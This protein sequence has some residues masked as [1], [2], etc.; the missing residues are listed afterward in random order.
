MRKRAQRKSIPVESVERQVDKT[1][2]MKLS[3]NKHFRNKKQ[4]WAA[5][6]LI[7][8]FLMVLL[9]TSFFNVSSGEPFN[10][11]G[12]GFSRYYLA[13][14][15]P[16]YNMRI[17][18]ET[19]YGENAGQYPFYGNDDPLLNYPLGR[20][21]GR[22]PFM[23]VLA[24]STGQ[25]L[26][27][28][29]DEVDAVGYAMQFLPALFGALLVFPIYFIGKTLFNKKV[30]LL[31]ALL[32]ALIPVHLG[33]GHG[34]AYALFDH[35]SL[36]LFLIVTSYLFVIKG[37]T[38][39][40]KNKSYLYAL[41]AGICVAA[42]TMVWV[43]ARYLFTMIALY[44][45]VQIIIDIYLG[46]KDVSV[47]RTAS[48]TL[49]S[50][51]LISLP[52]IASRGGFSPDLNLYLALGVTAFG[53]IYYLFSKKNIPWTLSLPAIFG[54][55]AGGVVFLYF[56]PTVSQYF[57]VFG[58]L[59]KIR[60][61]LFGAG[62]Y[63][64]K[65]SMTI[66]EAGTFDMSRTVMSFGPALFWIAWLGFFILGYKYLVKNHRRDHF[67]LLFLFLVQIW[68]ITIAGR[69]INDLIPPITLL[70]A[71]CIW[72]IIDRVDYPSMIRG[73]KQVG[74]LQGLRKGVSFLHI[75]GILFIAFLLILPNAYLSL[76]AAVPAASKNEV[77]GDL[78]S[79]AF[80][81][82]FG[83][84]MYWVAAY[85]WLAEQDNEIPNPVDRPGFISWW[86]Y[87][88][89]GAAIGEHPM[90]ADNFQDGIPPASNFHTSTSEYEAV[91]ILAIRL[92]EGEAKRGPIN[93]NIVNK[94]KTYLDED[95]ANDF[96][97][98][99]EEPTRSPS[100]GAPIAP[101]Y[102]EE[103]SRDWL[104]G[105]RYPITAVYHDGVDLLTDKLSDD[106][107]I[108]LYRDIQ[109]LTGNSIRYYGVEGYDRQIFNIFGFL[110]DKSLLMVAG[111][112]EYSPEDDFTQLK[113]VTD[114]GQQLTLDEVLDRTDLEN[115]QD[116]IVD[117]RTLYK[118]AY[119]ETMFYKTY[120]GIVQTDQ[121]GR[122][123]T[124]QYQL[125]CSDMKHFYAQYVSPYPEYAYAQGQSAV[126][127]A[128]YY[129]GA[130]INGS[131][132]FLDSPKDF[133]VVVQQNIT[134]YG[135]QVP[136]DHDRNQSVN[137]SYEV[138]VPAGDVTLQ[139]RRYPELEDNAFEMAT[140]T[141]GD[142]GDYPV[143][144]E[145]EATR[146]AESYRRHIDITIPTASLEG[147][148]YDPVDEEAEEFN[149]T[150]DAPLADATVII[151]G[152]DAL[153]PQQGTP[154][155][156][157]W[158]HIRE[159]TTDENGYYNA[160]SLL[161]GYY[162]ILVQ[163]EAGFQI[164]NTLI[165][166]QGGDNWHN[167]SKPQEGSVEGTVYFDENNN[168]EYDEG[169]ELSGVTIDVIYTAT[170][171]NNIV[172]TIVTDE[173][174][175]Y[176]TSEFLP[177]LYEL[178]ATKLPDYETTIQVNIPENDTLTENIMIQY[179]MIDVSGETLRD[180]TNQPVANMTITFTVDPTVE[181]NT[182]NDT[183]TQSDETGSYSTELMPGSYLVA[184]DEMVNETGIMVSYTF[185]GTLNIAVGQDPVTYDVPLI[186]EEE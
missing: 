126:V 134:H 128:K 101:E 91:S 108:M 144:T 113:Y 7:A 38:A 157:D 61:I 148:V 24:I 122:K 35:D 54:L 85:D 52:V 120:V 185:T 99:I 160:S 22:G 70:G 23:N 25:L 135:T 62:V 48:I 182:A 127:I 12:S 139:V 152:I 78:P 177:G 28:F 32:I 161:P 20:S 140:V 26:S 98:W 64:D 172:E 93:T 151:Y 123:S 77:F 80:G 183:E 137:G 100:Y 14:P 86:D 179:A 124:P 10:E 19:L 75:F 153:D 92:L 11:E 3:K 158:D 90:V 87:G 9:L 30:G 72:L 63:G 164:E 170:G 45:I 181:N 112:G 81:S 53:A 89:Y 15:D 171:T 136:I 46:K 111:M 55:G 43:E 146:T 145:A 50:G 105:E 107:I 83:K 159:L 60:S 121:E 47:P 56:L 149:E 1:L 5:G 180:D 110:A 18:D 147:Y 66:A 130:F 154:T 163:T 141:F 13:G 173:N 69:F 40:D 131:I 57:P 143:I 36:N 167:V 162:Q 94:I 95:D 142:T 174:G 49:L 168:G 104:V 96:V 106:E 21:G 73:I 178:H 150:V 119:F 125:P 39:L 41:L 115:Q 59:G 169:E 17:V 31:A 184:V 34:S 82:S 16:Y 176:S 109:D 132:Q 65:V 133:E 79:G 155:A 58:G 117:T 175:R 4:W 76:D 44:A 88:F 37:V 116:P 186:R 27:P 42:L 84:E 103:F 102:G 97:S 166:V 165:P 29:M 8:I 138:I 2:S 33:S 71:M 6:S 129:E 156:Y 114:S 118:D 51:Y 68:F 74:G 67:F